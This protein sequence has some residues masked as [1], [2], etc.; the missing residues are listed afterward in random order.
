MFDS[1]VDRVFNGVIGLVSELA[2]GFLWALITM[3]ILSTFPDAPYQRVLLYVAC[4]AV[5]FWLLGILM[6]WGA[7]LLTRRLPLAKE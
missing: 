7:G 5:I 1:L 2:Y 3:S 4:F 6:R